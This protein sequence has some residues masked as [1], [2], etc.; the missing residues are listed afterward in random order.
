MNILKEE[1]LQNAFDRHKRN[2]EELS[3]GLDA[4]GLHLELKP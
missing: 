3:S 4:L 2:Q 1:G